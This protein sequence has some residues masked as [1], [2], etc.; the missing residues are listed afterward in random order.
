MLLLQRKPQ[1]GRTKPSTG[2]PTARRPRLAKAGLKVRQ[3]GQSTKRQRCV[4]QVF[5]RNYLRKRR[6]VFIEEPHHS[7]GGGDVSTI[8]SR[9]DDIM[10]EPDSQNGS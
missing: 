6:K 1:L 3:K 9:P 10:P 8:G 5:Q 2:S 4:G 7:K